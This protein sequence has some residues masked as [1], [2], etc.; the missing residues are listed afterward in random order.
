MLGY[1]SALCLRVDYVTIVDTARKPEIGTRAIVVH[2]SMLDVSRGSGYP[3]ILFVASRLNAIG[4][5]DDLV[6]EGITSTRVQ[7][8]DGPHHLLRNKTAYSFILFLPQHLT[9]RVLT[10]RLSGGGIKVQW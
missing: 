2:A 9:E 10:S 7:L 8:Y 5:T 1:G 3:F 6:E 4:I